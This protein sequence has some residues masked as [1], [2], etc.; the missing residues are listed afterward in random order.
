MVVSTAGSAHLLTTEHVRPHHRAVVDSGFSP[1]ADG[2]V[3]GDIHPRAAAVPQNITPVPGGVGP[4]EMA[5][6]MERIVR[7]VAD[8]ALQ[9]W[10]FPTTPYLTDRA[11]AA[12]LRS[13]GRSCG[14]AS[15]P[16]T[17]P[18]HG[19]APRPTQGTDT[20]RGGPSR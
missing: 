1:Q 20:K 7:Q 16:R 2:S 10:T 17:G 8:P 18:D 9:P 19:A 11:P 6:L 4:V 3:A 15:A 12:R 14:P 5:V 13:T